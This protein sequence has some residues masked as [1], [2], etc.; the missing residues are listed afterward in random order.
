MDTQY[1]LT[2]KP[3]LLAKVSYSPTKDAM[4]EEIHNGIR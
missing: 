4:R 3:S 1:M 2:I